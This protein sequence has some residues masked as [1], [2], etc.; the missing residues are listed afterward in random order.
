[1]T[2]FWST[3]SHRVPA[4]NS[5]SDSWNSDLRTCLPH[6]LSP[7][8]HSVSCDWPVSY[9]VE[10][11]SALSLQKTGH[12]GLGPGACDLLPQSLPHSWVPGTSPRP[13]RRG[14]HLDQSPCPS[15]LP[16]PPRPPGQQRPCWPQTWW[17]GRVS[18]S[19]AASSG[20]C[21]YLGRSLCSPGRSFWTGHCLDLVA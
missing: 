12:G 18:R 21:S 2:N 19:C 10:W 15:W 6:P 1:M 8:A 17:K 20:N 11:G 16:R 5:P 14:E 3:Q 4:T 7:S 13:L 9:A